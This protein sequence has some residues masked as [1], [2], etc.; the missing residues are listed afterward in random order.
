MKNKE[1]HIN[2]NNWTESTKLL[3][4]THLL[5]SI[6]WISFSKPS[7]KRSFFLLFISL[8]SPLSLF[9]F[10]S[11]SISSTSYYNNITCLFLQFC[12][13]QPTFSTSN[14]LLFSFTFNSIQG[15]TLK[16]MAANTPTSESISISRQFQT[17]YVSLILYPRAPSSPFFKRSNISTFLEKF[18]NICN[19]YQMSTSEKIRRLLL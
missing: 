10:L 7:I 2:E 9:F 15:I 17:P 14:L 8:L 5:I 1:I 18:E 16:V 6:N 11:Q 13:A 19:N 4:S 12:I 3:L